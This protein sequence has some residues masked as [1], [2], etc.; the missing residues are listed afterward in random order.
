MCRRVQKRVVFIM[1][2]VMLITSLTMS[3]SMAASAK[4]D[5]KPKLVETV[6]VESYDKENKR[7]KTVNTYEF[8]YNK[9]GDPVRID[10]DWVG[11]RSEY[12]T[13][14][15]YKYRENGKRRSAS[16]KTTGVEWHSLGGEYITYSESGKMLYNKKGQRTKNTNNYKGKYDSGQSAGKFKTTTKYKVKKAGFYLITSDPD[17]ERIKFKVTSWEKGILKRIKIKEFAWEDWSTRYTF[18][19][20]GLLKKVNW[21]TTC[22]YKY[23]KNTGLVKTAITESDYYGSKMRYTFTYTDKS[24]S[25][26]RYSTMINSFLDSGYCYEFIW[27]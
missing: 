14:L 15:S 24:I 25:K 2:A 18:N 22:R 23:D 12:T 13:T 10:W 19:K 11:Y 17:I 9:K 21:A 3:S 8:A 1:T 26:M 7:W 5:K 16:Y 20:K 6:K 27:Y 4:A